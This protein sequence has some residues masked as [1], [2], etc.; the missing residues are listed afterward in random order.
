MSVM[1]LINSM[2][3]DAVLLTRNDEWLERQRLQT[4]QQIDQLAN[5][6]RALM[7]AQ[8]IKRLLQQRN[9]VA[10]QYLL[11][12]ENGSVR[13]IVIRLLSLPEAMQMMKPSRDRLEEVNRIT[14]IKTWSEDGYDLETSAALRTA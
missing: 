7:L 10:I 5:E 1:E 13:D 6:L 11:K 14:Q 9:L 12:D 2:G 4:A 3:S 8:R